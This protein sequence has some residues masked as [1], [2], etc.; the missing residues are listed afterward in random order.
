[1]KRVLIVSVFALLMSNIIVAQN[2]PTVIS[3]NK[4][5]DFVVGNDSAMHDTVANPYDVLIENRPVDPDFAT[6][7]FAIIDKEQKFYM[8]LG[9]TV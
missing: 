6:P 4:K 8:S 1:M 3:E 7:H 5:I 9:A 2:H